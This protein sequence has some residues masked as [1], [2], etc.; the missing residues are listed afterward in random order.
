MACAQRMHTR[1]QS[2]PPHTPREYAQLPVSINACRW[3]HMSSEMG[4]ARAKRCVPILLLGLDACPGL[5]IVS[6]ALPA[7]RHR[8]LEDSSGGPKMGPRASPRSKF[9][10]GRV[11]EA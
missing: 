8:R 9:L 7:A 5:A 2:N 1:R 10:G 3:V 11:R 6:A 4:G